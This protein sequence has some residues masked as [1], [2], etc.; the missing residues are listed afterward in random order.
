MIGGPGT[1][2]DEE[3]VLVGLLQHGKTFGIL[4]PI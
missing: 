2:A 1:G 3:N 4:W